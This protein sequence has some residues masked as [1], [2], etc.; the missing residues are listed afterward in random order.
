V[1]IAVATVRHRLADGRAEP[2]DAIEPLLEVRER[3]GHRADGQ[4][5]RAF[6]LR[7]WRTLLVVGLLFGVALE[8]VGSLRL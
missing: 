6:R 1:T 7:L 2:G 4:L 5:G 3:L 8:V